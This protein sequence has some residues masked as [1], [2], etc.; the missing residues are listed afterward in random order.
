MTT[1]T[2]GRAANA[3]AGLLLLAAVA[4]YTWAVWQYFTLPVPGGNDFLARYTAWTAYFKL[5]LNPYSDAAT[6][7]TQQAFYGRPALPGE[8]LQRLTYPFYSVLVH[9][10]FTLLDYALARAVHITVLQAAI[11]LGVALTLRVMQWR[12]PVWLLALLVGWALL[13]YHMAR[14]VILGQVAIFGFLSLA[15]ALAL[16]A[17][18]RDAAAG[19][20]LVLATVKPPLVF[21][22]VPFLV[23]WALA[24]RRWRFLAGF[25][26]LLAA[27][28]LGSFA[29]LPTWFG[30]ML[31]RIQEYS[32]YTVGQSPLWVIT[33]E[34][35]PGLGAPVEWALLAVCG[36]WLLWAWWRA[37]VRRPESR[38]EFHW[39]LAVTLVVSNLV[40]SRSA[41][42]N[43][44]L[45]L[46]PTLWVFALLAAH[47]RAGRALL[48][49]V[50]AGA[51]V[52]PWWLHFA[53]VVGNQEQASMFFPWPAALLLVL[54]LERRWLLREAAAYDTARAATEP[55]VLLP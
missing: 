10:P 26:G 8:D 14:G 39:A 55:R 46:V 35:W 29:L 19:M 30:D 24:R 9:G 48:L 43:Y 4:G 15:G 25:F 18:G 53:T 41:T 12:P 32:S 45:L 54:T 42:T 34:W 2:R 44:V 47:G 16:L 40:V 51:L 52:G 13:D 38:P 36:A 28:C 1:V 22:V 27:L 7:Y 23:L 3:V 5:G 31:R 20:V 6:L 33:H 11:V 49:A 37:L 21:L 50:L 17:R